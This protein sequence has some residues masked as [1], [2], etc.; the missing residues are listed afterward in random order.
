MNLTWPQV[1]DIQILR[2]T[3]RA[4]W[5]PYENLKRR[6]WS[7][8]NSSSGVIAN[9][10]EV[11][12]TNRLWWPDL[13]WPGQFFLAKCAQW[14]FGKSHQVWAFYLEAFGNG[15]RKT[16]GGPKRPP[17][18]RN[19]VN[20]LPLS[21][22]LSTTLTLIHYSYPCPLST[23]TLNPYTYTYAYPLYLPLPFIQNPLLSL[24]LPQTLTLTLSH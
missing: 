9:F 15:T 24:P 7:V 4:W 13:T 16:W 20:P 11:G 10:S 22:L 3:N 8:K 6:N 23:L 12:S 14:M 5:Y 18:A 19:R 17:P 2:Y 1:T 21:L